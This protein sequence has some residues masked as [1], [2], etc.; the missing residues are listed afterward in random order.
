MIVGDGAILIYA[1]GACRGNGT[2]DA[3]A[4]VGIYAGPNHPRNQ[5]FEIRESDQ[6]LTNQVAELFAFI[7]AVQT[8]VDIVRAGGQ[9]ATSK[10]VI[11]TDSQYAYDGITKWINKWKE[12]DYQDVQN[13]PLFDK[14]DQLVIQVGIPVQFWKISR[15]DNVEADKLARIALDGD[16]REG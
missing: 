16:E 7:Y 10:L 11:A 6:R 12:K 1:D 5:G 4:S 3:R 14:L 8:G 13:A 9:F 2:P 15:E